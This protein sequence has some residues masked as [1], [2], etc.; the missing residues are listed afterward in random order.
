MGLLAQHLS[1]VD[2]R[3]FE[4]LELELG[5]G[6]TILVGPNASGK[7][8]TVEALQLL[9][10]GSSFRKPTPKQLV[11]EGAECGRASV[12]LAGDGRII[13]VSCDVK[14]GRKAFTR[15]GKHCQ[16]QEVS[17]TLLSI[18]F[19]PDDLMMVKGGASYRRDEID[20]FGR[21][22]AKGYANLMAAYTHAIEQRNRLL[23]EPYIDSD[24]L[25]AWDVSVARG[26]ASLLSARLR[27][28]GRLTPRIESAYVDISGG[29]MLTCTYIC[30]LGDEI[31]GRS[32]DELTQL[33]LNRLIENH[34]EDIRRQMTCV[35]P[36]R[37]DV[38]FEVDG[39]DARNFASQGQ[40]RSIVLAIKVAEVGL[41]DEVCGQRP[42]LLLDDVMSEL[43]AT[44][45]AAV[46]G[47]AGEGIQTIVTTT[48]L[49]Y[50]DDGVLQSAKVVHFGMG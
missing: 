15:N 32:R 9:T 36:H 44:R 12:R 17:G 16:A 13:D 37:D 40:Q 29:E 49:G 43:D 18:L 31:Q 41:A 24:L 45:R 48:N 22:A 1:L 42:L 14:T 11:R 21:Q 35:G 2:F 38:L 26:G 27:L 33:M 23:K 47:L 20:G 28:L 39:R 5:D 30:S 10:T 7:T 8:N 19:S 4:S 6:V 25:D 34:E 46:M 50:F 3:N